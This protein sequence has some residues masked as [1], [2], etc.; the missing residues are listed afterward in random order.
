MAQDFLP[1]ADDSSNPPQPPQSDRSGRGDR[2]PVRVM[3]VGSRP[4]ITRMIHTLHV[5]RVAPAD[6][7]SDFQIEPMTG[8]FMCILT[9][10]I[11]F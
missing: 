10:Y 5:K 6:E 2:E 4:G 9:K 1:D 7:W 11:D 8:Q 3:L